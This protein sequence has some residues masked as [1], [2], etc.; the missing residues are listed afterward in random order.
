[1][2]GTASYDVFVI[3]GGINGCGIAR[4]AAG[5]GFATGLAEMADLASGTS[6]W[7]T[8]LIHGGLRYLEHYE[9]RLVRESLRER[10]RLWHSAPHIIRPMRFVLPHHEGLRPAWLLRLG[11]LLYDTIG[12]R[13]ALPG[14]RTL[15][16][17]SDPAGKPLKPGFGRAFEYSDCWAD[18]SRLVAL[19]A[20][21]AADR[22]AV[23]RTRTKVVGARREGGAWSVTLEDQ[24]TGAREAVAAQLLVNAA[25]PWVDRVI[26]AAL[27][28]DDAHNVRLVQGSHIVVRAKFPGPRA[29]FFQTGD[30]RIIFAIPFH[31]DFTLIGTTDR[32]YDG[33][34]GAVTATEEEVAYLCA[35]ASEYF[36]DPVR[37]DD[38]VWSFSGV[39]PLFDDGASK[40]QEATRDYV[41]KV[42]GSAGAPALVNVFGGKLTT[43]RRLA[44]AVLARIEDRLGRRGPAWTAEAVL[45]GG[46]LAGGLDAAIA[47]FAAGHPWLP[48]RT[49]RRLVELYGSLASEALGGA[50]DVPG[51]GRSFGAGLHAAEVGYL[52]RR[53]WAQTAEDVLWR[54]TKLGL[55]V[56]AEEAAALDEHMAAAGRI[57][58]E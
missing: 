9:F 12:G 2:T 33:D 5:R 24:R 44:E 16:L 1:L 47:A 49:A 53:E 29:Y 35:A 31:D 18:D 11:L 15:S 54:R 40:A 45:P 48:E 38:V 3:G 20:R 8:K 7:S 13:K 34:P 55:R 52:M 32:D 39:R 21:D 50:R 23:V 26:A 58:A 43:Y 57:A 42:E 56:T 27:G 14:T 19:N 51:L 25:G 10:E 46:D 36:A 28:A 4:D 17:E 30:G 37:P 6:S 41:L 22:G